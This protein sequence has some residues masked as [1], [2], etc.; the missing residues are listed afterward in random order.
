MKYIYIFFNLIMKI[1][2]KLLISNFL[3]FTVNLNNNNNN[4]NNNTIIIIK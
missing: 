4:N 2:V 1:N 3:L